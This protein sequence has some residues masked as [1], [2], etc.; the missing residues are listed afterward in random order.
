VNQLFREILPDAS[1][2]KSKKQTAP[3]PKAAAVT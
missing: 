3:K 1:R 2:S